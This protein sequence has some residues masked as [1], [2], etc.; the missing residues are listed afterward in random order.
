MDPPCRLR[1]LQ[2]LSHQYLIASTVELYVGH[3][4]SEG[5]T[6]LNHAKFTRLGYV[7]LSKN[8]STRYKT[9]ELKSVNVDCAG[10]LVKLVLNQNHINQLNTYNQVGLVALNIIGEPIPITDRH[11]RGSLLQR[12]TTNAKLAEL[13][14]T[15]LP[16][17][18]L[19]DI[20]STNPV[21]KGSI[22][23]PKISP[24]DELSFAVAQDP[25]IAD[26][27]RKLER[28]KAAAIDEENFQEAKR[29]KMVVDELCRAGEVLCRY[30]V[31][32]K[33]AVAR[34][35]YDTAK[36]KKERVDNARRMIYNELDIH[37]LLSGGKRPT[38]PKQSPQHHPVQS[39][40]HSEGTASDRISKAHQRLLSMEDM[41]RSA[42][43]P[44]ITRDSRSP[45]PR[46]SSGE[47]PRGRLP[48]DERPLP[49]LARK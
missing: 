45:P 49:A 28:R 27:V 24:V 29:L 44:P 13:L 31:E 25:E 20:G 7:S 33:D 9:M 14:H 3:Y 19:S 26:L 35:D 15:Y 22:K 36:A 12:N 8:D 21:L 48:A 46:S 18:N 10:E 38:F 41:S 40:R 43:L 47:R 6:S 4:T 17:L 32:K 2:L 1:K 39:L 30:E 37:G 5:H 42:M 16:E 34:E 11:M 23:P